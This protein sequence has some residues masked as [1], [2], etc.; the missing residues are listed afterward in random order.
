M[1]R[2]G[3]TIM[4]FSIIVPI[5]GVEKYLR[6]CIDSILN[7]DFK[8]Y[9]LILVDDGS[10]DDCPD[11][12][13]EYSGQYQE[14]KVIHKK[15]GGLS[16]AR[17][18]GLKIAK[19]DY[20]IFVD[21]DDQ[22]K[23]KALSSINKKLKSSPDILITE[24]YD[25]ADMNANEK[26]SELFAMPE[27]NTYSSILKF[28]FQEKKHAWS[29]PQYIIKRNFIER[30]NLE[31][32]EGYYHEDISW[33]SKLFS[34]VATYEFYN[35]VWYI[36][37][38]DRPGSIMNV[39]KAK[40]TTDLITLVSNE[41]NSKNYDCLKEE[42]K[43][44]IFVR[45]VKSVFISLTNCSKYTQEDKSNIALLLRQN[46]NLWNYTKGV[47]YKIFIFLINILGEDKCINLLSCIYRK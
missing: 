9:E 31:F 23:E 34:Q 24:I 18:A 11:I 41:I 15:N 39:P 20:I 40:R 32:A 45:L 10:P 17:N 21:A 35:S 47:K 1:G 16:S 8:S 44:I 19:G 36:R 37:R 2:I 28:V 14:V 25:T 26:T 3:D 12:C 27:S 43:N 42:E 4:K 38:I 5:F 46:K 7:Q 30:R 33:T 6:M 13:D 29:A 22:I